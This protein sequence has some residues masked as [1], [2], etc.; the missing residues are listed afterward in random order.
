MTARPEHRRIRSAEELEER[1]LEFG[2]AACR[3]AG[4]L[5]P[6]LVNRH[7]AGQ[8]VR[9]ATAPVANYAEACAAPSRKGFV[10]RLRV[11]LQEL[12]ETRVWLALLARCDPAIATAAL[13][14]ECR[15]LIAILTRSINTATR[16]K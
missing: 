16:G 13:E 8:L 1:L 9:A 11:C 7:I 15:E 5:Q 2:A 12:R 4:R 14:Q 6:S 10:Y 3:L